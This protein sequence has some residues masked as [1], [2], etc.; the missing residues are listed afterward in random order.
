M[1]KKEKINYLKENYY[2]EWINK[3]SEIKNKLSDNQ[4]IFCCCGKL[5]TGMHE[6]NCRKFIQ[7]VES[8]TVEKLS[9]LL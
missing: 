6:N 4:D 1:T 2:S 3:Y 9:S 5:A 7:K 8:K